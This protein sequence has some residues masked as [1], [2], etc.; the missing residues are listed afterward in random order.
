[1]RLI[2]LREVVSVVGGGTPRKSSPE[3]YG[4]PI[5]WVTPK[6]MKRHVITTSLVTLTQQGVENSPAKV[7]PRDTVLVVVRS[8]VL[9]HTLPVALTGVPV[10]LNQDMKG[11]IPRESIHGPYLARLVKALEPTVLSWVR[12]T[13]ADNFP[14]EKLL[15][16]EINLPDLVEQRRIAAIL[17]HV[18]AIRVTQQEIVGAANELSQSLFVEMFGDPIR[19]PHGYPLVPLAEVGAL[20]RGV[21]KHRPRND[22]ALLGGSYPLIQTGDVAKSDGYITKYTSTYSELGLAQSKLWPSGTLCITIAANIAQTGVLAFPACFPDSVVG[23]TADEPTTAFIRVWLTFLQATLEASAPQSAQRNINLAILR[24][25]PVPLPSPADRQRFS[26]A[27]QQINS[28]RQAWQQSSTA[29]DELFA[30]LQ[31]RAFRGEL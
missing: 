10:T 24:Q 20:D 14:I 12:A 18:D 7:V 28:Q 1:M 29:L 30:S 23:F 17:D 3:F 11:L 26:S 31:S 27:L 25:L 21:S 2:P 9:K 22:P 19:N 13:T 5:P 4:G 15:D 8:G 16:F 6:D